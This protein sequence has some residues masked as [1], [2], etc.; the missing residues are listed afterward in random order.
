LAITPRTALRRKRERGSHERA[1][2]ESILDEGL[3]AN[4]GFVSDGRPV[5]LPMAYARLGQVLYLHGASANHLLR[6][7]SGAAV[8]VTVTLVDAL[9]L[10]RS[11]FHH[12]MNY[13]SAVLFGTAATVTDNDEKS[14]ALDALV[15]HMVP[16]RTRDARPPTPSELR[17]TLVV[18]LPIDEGSAKIRTGPPIDDD[19]DL[20]LDVWAGVIPLQIVAGAPVP[21]RTRAPGVTRPDY[22]AN[23]LERRGVGSR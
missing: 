12:S 1:V 16:G 20:D 11:A 4:V 5:V 2:V 19:E 8:C 10:A 9:V 17:A 21:D 6:S 22:V 14:R 7:I 15:E 18:R 23:A 3:V 13:R